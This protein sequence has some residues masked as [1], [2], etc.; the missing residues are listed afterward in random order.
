[1]YKVDFQVRI[2]RYDS[3]NINMTLLELHF[4]YWRS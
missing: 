1:V 4:Q 2:Y 3:P